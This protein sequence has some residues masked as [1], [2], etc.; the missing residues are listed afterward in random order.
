[1]TRRHGWNGS[2]PADESEARAR[3]LEAAVRC[4]DRDG[5]DQFSLSRVAAELGVIR[6]TVY[7]YYPSTDEL[8][9]SVSQASV[10]SFLDEMRQ[11]LKSCTRPADWAVELLAIAIEEVPAKRYLILLLAADRPMT[12]TQGVVSDEAMLVAMEAARSSSVDWASAGY[13]DQRLSELMELVLR[14][15]QSMVVTPPTPPRT[16]S[17]LRGFL[18]RWLAPAI[19][20]RP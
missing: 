11:R 6:A 4:I 10:E 16:G 15:I 12:F 17:E 2:P 9:S 18:Q 8:L 7:R 13:D 5:P 19:A 1:M 20:A 14:I 3:I